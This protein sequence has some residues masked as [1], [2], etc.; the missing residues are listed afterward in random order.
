VYS[1]FNPQK[2]RPGSHPGTLHE[3]DY[4]K[5]TPLKTYALTLLS[6]N[7]MAHAVLIVSAMEPSATLI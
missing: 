4:Q 3:T 7:V 5:T 2:K 6:V 1:A